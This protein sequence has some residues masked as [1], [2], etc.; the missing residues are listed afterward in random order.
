M[1]DLT[2]GKN[3]E[4]LQRYDV[5][6]PIIYALHFQNLSNMFP[7]LFL[8]HGVFSRLPHCLYI[9]KPLNTTIAFDTYVIFYIEIFCCLD[10]VFISNLTIIVPCQKYVSLWMLLW[11]DF[12][13]SSMKVGGPQK[14]E[15]KW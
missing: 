15:T 2:I 11:F 1:N 8:V 3:L 9:I 4:V 14:K 13:L 6:F 7:H 12:F 10:D 5:V